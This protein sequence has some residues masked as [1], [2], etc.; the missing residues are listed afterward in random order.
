MTA[1]LAD[2]VI[3]RVSLNGRM[4]PLFRRRALKAASV[5]WT[6]LRGQLKLPSSTLDV[7]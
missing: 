7:F 1:F 6:R 4:L 5:D 3:A 2:E